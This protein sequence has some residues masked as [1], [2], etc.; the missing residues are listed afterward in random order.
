MLKLK[1]DSKK[2]NGFMK[3]IVDKIEQ[4][5]ATVELENGEII[6]IPSKLIE[7]AEEGDVVEITVCK[8]ETEERQE[9]IQELA[10]KLFE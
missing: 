7:E 5:I 8:K 10:N 2:G 1:Q 4:E 6:N 3:I 9:K